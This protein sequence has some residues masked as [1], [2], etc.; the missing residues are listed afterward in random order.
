MIRI[1]FI[2]QTESLNTTRM[3]LK[4]LQKSRIKFMLKKSKSNMAKKIILK[5]SQKNIRQHVMLYKVHEEKSK[6]DTI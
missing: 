3:N 1:L 2:H 5:I 4:V 6:L